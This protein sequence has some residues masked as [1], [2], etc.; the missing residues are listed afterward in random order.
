M[1]KTVE[2]LGWLWRERLAGGVALL[3]LLRKPD[4]EEVIF[5]EYQQKIFRQEIQKK[6]FS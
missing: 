1:G 2:S 5:L 4:R 6:R 3:E